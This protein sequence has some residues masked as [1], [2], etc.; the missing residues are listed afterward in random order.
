MTAVLIAT[1]GL[2]LSGPMSR[3]QGV[4]DVRECL[5]SG[6]AEAERLHL[7]PMLERGVKVCEGSAFLAAGWWHVQSRWRRLE[8]VGGCSMATDNTLPNLH[9][10]ARSIFP[11]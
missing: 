3:S 8:A 6:C 5:G 10:A 11:G 4:G 1:I 7:T 2:S 9:G